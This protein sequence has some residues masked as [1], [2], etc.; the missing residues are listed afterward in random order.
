MEMVKSLNV[1]CFIAIRQDVI[2]WCSNILATRCK[3]YVVLGMG[4][5][6][7]LCAS[8]METKSIGMDIKMGS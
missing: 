2:R 1:K 7:F 8:P 4:R 3:A 6:V 5:M